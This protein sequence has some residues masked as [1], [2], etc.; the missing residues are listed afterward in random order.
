M[1]PITAIQCSKKSRIIILAL[2]CIRCKVEVKFSTVRSFFQ[3]QLDILGMVHGNVTI[4]RSTAQNFSKNWIRIAL[5]VYYKFA[6]SSVSIRAFYQKLLTIS[7]STRDNLVLD[8]SDL[9]KDPKQITL[10]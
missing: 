3:I 2:Q 1:M 9:H 7:W 8:R 6:L 10:Y 4:S 5:A